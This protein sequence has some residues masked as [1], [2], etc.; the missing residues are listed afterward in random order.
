MPRRKNKKST[1]P[2]SLPLLVLSLL[3]ASL[4]VYAY[5]RFRPVSPGQIFVIESSNL[6]SGPATLSGVISR[7]TPPSQ[8]GNYYLA[9]D[10]GQLIA[11]DQ[12]DLLD[13]LGYNVIVEGE[14]V[15]NPDPTVAPFLI[16]NTLTITE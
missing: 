15:V 16:V 14:L 4:G 10:N 6:S 1:S 12:A 3:I 11:L 5:V 2:F 8:P 9:L 13:L 7:D